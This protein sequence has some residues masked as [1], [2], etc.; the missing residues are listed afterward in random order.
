MRL[1]RP[2][3]RQCAAAGRTGANPNRQNARFRARFRFTL[4]TLFFSASSTEDCGGHRM[5]ITLD[6]FHDF[7][8]H[9]ASA[10]E[11]NQRYLQVSPGPMRSMLAEA[12]SSRVHVFRKWMSERVVQQGG[13]PAGRLCFAVGHVQ[14]EGIPRAQGR[15]L[16]GENLFLLRGGDDF[17]LQRPRGME[18]L[19][20]T[21]EAEAFHRMLDERPLPASARRQLSQQVLQASPEAV[22]RLRQVLLGILEGSVAG[23]VPGLDEGAAERAV[24]EALCGVV[25]GAA[26]S[27]HSVANASADFIVS[28]CH[29]IV[30]ASGDAPPGIDA[31]CRRLRTSRRS[32][33]NGF[34]QMADTTPV[35]YL[36]SLRLNAVRGRLLSTPSSQL[37][38]SQAAEDQGFRHLSHF[39]QRYKALFGELPSATARA[40]Q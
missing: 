36:R 28:E 26:G 34:R 18:L 14:G 16:N 11:W 27:L 30:A 12:T 32:L 38:V 17:T 31:L 1:A 8:L 2:A 21:F 37:S 33:Q 23:G 10:P 35:H 39:T 15:A 19:A 5:G 3:A 22:R 4:A 20:V 25:E 29:R 7:H 9:G 6:V 24:F 13:L 40:P